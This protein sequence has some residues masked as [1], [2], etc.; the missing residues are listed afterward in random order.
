MSPLNL[1]WQELGCEEYV[2][3]KKEYF[4]ILLC[5]QLWRNIGR[6]ENP[7]CKCKEQ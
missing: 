6:E 2:V 3:P 7:E 4:P 5:L 1:Y